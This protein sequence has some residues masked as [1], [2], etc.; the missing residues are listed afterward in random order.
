MFV[1]LFWNIESL[2]GRAISGL[3]SRQLVFVVLLHVRQ[4]LL[5]VLLHFGQLVLVILP[6]FL[7]LDFKFLPLL[8]DRLIP[9][10]LSNN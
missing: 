2:P 3:K 10:A 9:V 7:Q 5:V 4:L 1:A 8:F 6:L